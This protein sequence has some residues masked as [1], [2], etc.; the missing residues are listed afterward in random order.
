MRIRTSLLLCVMSNPNF[1]CFLAGYLPPPPP[2]SNPHFVFNKTVTEI[3]YVSKKG[4]YYRNNS[5][6]TCNCE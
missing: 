1:G 4:E 5:N 6:H 3:N 2:Q